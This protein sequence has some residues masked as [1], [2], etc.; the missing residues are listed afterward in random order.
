MSG[1]DKSYLAHF[2]KSVAVGFFFLFLGGVAMNDNPVL[3]WAA[4]AVTI[5]VWIAGS[6][7]AADAE[8]DDTDK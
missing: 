2:V 1:N 8:L 6:L 5:V 4:L 7:V 3:T